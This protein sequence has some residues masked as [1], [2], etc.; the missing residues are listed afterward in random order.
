MPTLIARNVP[1]T[2]QN[3][4]RSPVSAKSALLPVVQPSVPTTAMLTPIV[5]NAAMAEPPASVYRGLAK[6]VLPMAALNAP[7][8]ATLTP[9]A[10]NVP[11]IAQNVSPFRASQPK[12]VHRLAVAVTNASIAKQT[13]IALNAPGV[14]SAASEPVLPSNSASSLHKKTSPLAIFRKIVVHQRRV[15]LRKQTTTLT[16]RNHSMTTN[17]ILRQIATHFSDRIPF[18]QFLGFKVT[19]FDTERVELRFSFD[20]KLVGNMAQQILHGGVTSS[21]L[22]V[23]G[24][25]MAI[26]GMVEQMD[27]LDPETLRQRLSKVGT[28]NLRVDYLRPGRG[29]EF[30][31][32]ARIIRSGNKVAVTSMEMHNSEG[33]HIAFGTGTYLIG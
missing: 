11:T 24:G 10:L 19:E 27:E 26:A 21:A 22:D 25:L 31:A 7:T 4:N 15:F 30:I 1:T 23:V 16:K 6:S 12:P 2:A 28:V 32:S 14:K 18:H 33:Q 13:P 17:V 29:E 20:S 8:P 5:L 9:I 3:A